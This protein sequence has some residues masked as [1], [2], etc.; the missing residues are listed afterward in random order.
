METYCETYFNNYP[1][2]TTNTHLLTCT[3]LL[4]KS[5]HFLDS[6]SLFAPILGVSSQID[7]VY[8]PEEVLFIIK[9]VEIVVGF[10]AGAVTQSSSMNFS[11]LLGY[12][13]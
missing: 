2:P 5:I 4:G 7:I 12:L 11:R 3:I 8:V 6:W 13:E 9:M 1:F 10:N